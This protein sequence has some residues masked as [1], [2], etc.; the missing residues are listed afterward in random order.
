MKYEQRKRYEK[1]WN[2]PFYLI[3]YKIEPDVIHVHISGS[4]K[5]VYTIKIKNNKCDCDCPDN[6][7]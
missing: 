5:N 1:I 2:E 4:T 6:K 7:T 3:D